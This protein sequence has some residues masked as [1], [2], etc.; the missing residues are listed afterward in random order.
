[1]NN[2]LYLFLIILFNVNFAY[3]T[4]CTDV[5]S[6]ARV[7]L[8]KSDYKA[9]LASQNVKIDLTKHHTPLVNNKLHSDSFHSYVADNNCIVTA[10]IS[11][12]D[13]EGNAVNIYL[14][15]TFQGGILKSLQ[16]NQQYHQAKAYTDEEE[17]IVFET[18]R[19]SCTT[20]TFRIVVDGR[21]GHTRYR[22]WKRNKTSIEPDL[23]LLNGTIIPLVQEDCINLHVFKNLS[24]SYEISGDHCLQ[25]TLVVKKKGKV[26]LR[27]K[28]N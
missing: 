20:D 5:E 2:Y 26:I 14:K 13:S 11:A 7:L 3:A 19:I 8:L 24:Y 17:D 18:P 21:D 10:T 27:R 4:N 25:K 16:E 23:T 28:C 9:E 12:K 6:K 15:L 1:M 22:G